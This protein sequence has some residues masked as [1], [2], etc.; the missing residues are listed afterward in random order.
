VYCSP[1]HAARHLWPLSVVESVRAHQLPVSHS[2]RLNRSS[3]V[4][5]AC[6]CAAALVWISP[7]SL[8]WLSGVWPAPI[9]VLSYRHR[10][11]V[12]GDSFACASN[13]RVESFSCSLRAI[14]ARSTLISS[15]RRPCRS[16]SSLAIHREVPCCQPPHL[17]YAVVAGLP[18]S[19]GG[20]ALP[21]SPDIDLVVVEVKLSLT[22]A[23][24]S[25]KDFIRRLSTFSQALSQI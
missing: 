9:R 7:K 3:P 10:R 2:I 14:S 23:K 4:V 18:P 1:V 5:P 11:V 21:S 15:R 22:L 20:V 13:S 19:R 16:L 12:A 17:S 8:P 25:I 6:R 24:G